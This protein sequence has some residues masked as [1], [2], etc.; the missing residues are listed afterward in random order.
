MSLGQS[1]Q[2]STGFTLVEVIVALAVVAIALPVLVT[3]F[4]QQAD[5]TAY[6]RDRTTAQ[7]VA[8]NKLTEVRMAA[9]AIQE[10]EVSKETGS[11]LFAERDWYWLVDISAAPGVPNFYRIEVT[12]S[13]EEDVKAASLY[14]LAGFMSGDFRQDTSSF[15]GGNPPSDTENPS[16]QNNT[17]DARGLPDNL[18]ELRERAEE[19]GAL[20]NF[21]GG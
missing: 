10:L 16:D 5:N 13:T 3:S 8:A 2:Q 17:P 6:L 19:S 4:Y 21:N 9:R 11:S 18:E 1:K 20:E 14:T 7:M 12:V 15:G